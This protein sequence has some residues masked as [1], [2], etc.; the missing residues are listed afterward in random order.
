MALD[1]EQQF[2]NKD[3]KLYNYGTFDRGYI[4]AITDCQLNEINN[5]YKSKA[6]S[7]LKLTQLNTGDNILF[8]SIEGTNPVQIY[9]ATIISSKSGTE[10]VTLKARTNGQEIN[11]KTSNGATVKGDVV[12]K[13]NGIYNIPYYFDGYTWVE[14]QIKYAHNLSDEDYNGIN[15]N[16][17]FDLFDADKVKLDNTVTYPNSTF[18]GCKLFDYKE[19]TLDDGVYS[20]D[21]YDEKGNVTIYG[22]DRFIINEDED[23]NY[24]FSNNLHTDTFKYTPPMDYEKE[25]A[26]LDSC[27]AKCLRIL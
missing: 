9:T 2:Y 12:K 19:A 1:Y 27:L 26:L 13:I 24:I 4:V 22:L 10:I 8:K 7:K 25:I 17:L 23:K 14:G 15:Q 6:L 11:G 16:P 21:E 5:N 18:K 20:G 3:I